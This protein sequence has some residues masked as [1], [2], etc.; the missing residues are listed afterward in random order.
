[1]SWVSLIHL[2]TFYKG[3]NLDGGDDISDAMRHTGGVPVDVNG[4]PNPVQ[5]KLHWIQSGISVT[6]N[7]PTISQRIVLFKL[8][9][10]LFI[11]RNPA[12]ATG[13][14]SRVLFD[15]AVQLGGSSC[16]VQV[17]VPESKTERYVCGIR[18][19]LSQS[20]V[21]EMASSVSPLRFLF[22]V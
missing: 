13:S 4:F 10:M 16:L 11:L 8:N 3:W 5:T 19:E 22:P 17:T 1:M 2:N 6:Y 15:S 21:S 9:R 12:A 20:W 18:V 7:Q 14:N